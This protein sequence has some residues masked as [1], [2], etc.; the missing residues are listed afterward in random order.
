MTGTSLD[1]VDISLINS[2]GCNKIIFLGGKTYKFSNEIK[3]LLRSCFG[4]K[5]YDSIINIT[6][7][8]YTDFIIKK[9]NEFLKS[10]K[11]KIDV[12]GFHGQTINHKPNLGFSWQLGNAK[13]ISKYFL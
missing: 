11:N 8:K 13:K 10:K 1:G 9:I 12:I 7:S 4:A 3:K 5:K 2:D 6:E